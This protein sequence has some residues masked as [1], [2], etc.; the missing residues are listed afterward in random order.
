MQ[1]TD[2]ERLRGRQENENVKKK[3]VIRL[4]NLPLVNENIE[5]FQRMSRDFP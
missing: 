3:N 1:E 4:L 2:T 5:Y